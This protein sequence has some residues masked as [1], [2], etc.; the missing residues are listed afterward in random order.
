MLSSICRMVLLGG[1]C[2][3]TGLLSWSQQTGGK[4]AFPPQ[5]MDVGVTLAF[6]RA[7]IA[8]GNCDCFWFKGGGTDLSL[9][10]WKG[11]GFAVALSGDHS[12]NVTPGIDV[13]KISYLFGP[14]YTFLPSALN[15]HFEP[16]HRTQAFGEALFGAV[17]AFNGS[18]PTAMGLTASADSFAMQLGGGIQIPLARGFSVRLVEADYVRTS[19]P[20]NISNVQNDL[21]LGFGLSYHLSSLPHRR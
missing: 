17:H 21:R 14:R 12:S 3:A 7:Y 1:A 15:Q 5:S 10:I 11:L 18:F 6:E 8:P 13:N 4:A 9:P 16:L 19:L 2:M 20:N